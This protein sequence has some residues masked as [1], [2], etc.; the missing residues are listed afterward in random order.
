M[1]MTATLTTIFAPNEEILQE[2]YGNLEDMT[3]EMFRLINQDPEMKIA[4][5]RFNNFLAKFPPKE[6]TELSYL[7]SNG[8]AAIAI[9][10]NSQDRKAYIINKL[11]PEYKKLADKVHGTILD[12]REVPLTFFLSAPDLDPFILAARTGIHDRFN[13]GTGYFGKTYGDPLSPQDYEDWHEKHNLLFQLLSRFVLA[14]RAY[15]AKKAWSLDLIDTPRSFPVH[16]PGYEGK[17]DDR[18]YILMV[19]S[20]ASRPYQKGLTIQAFK[21]PELHKQLGILSATAGHWDLNQ[22]NIITMQD[23]GN[24]ALY[25]YE[26]PNNLNQKPGSPDN[27]VGIDNLNRQDVTCNPK[28]GVKHFLQLSLGNGPNAYIETIKKIGNDLNIGQY[29]IDT[30]IKAYLTGVQ[31]AAEAYK[32]YSPETEAIINSSLDNLHTK[33]GAYMPNN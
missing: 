27:T 18:N 13:I 12:K 5:Q 25:D 28:I 9:M 10:P 4:N 22:D 21:N 26:Q 11:I 6:R 7:L 8:A 3:P 20:F 1:A 29:T 14:E 15:L 30:A 17:L 2:L 31:T 24:V 33:Y 23:T 32:K 19:Q 16:L